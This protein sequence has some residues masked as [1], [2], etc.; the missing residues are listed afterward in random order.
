MVHVFH[1]SDFYAISST[2]SGQLEHTRLLI[3]L[4]SK[5]TIYIHVSGQNQLPHSGE[6][7]VQF[8]NG[9]F[10]LDENVTISKMED[11][12]STKQHLELSSDGTASK[13]LPS[14]MLEQETPSV[15]LPKSS[16]ALLVE[17]ADSDIRLNQEENIEKAS[18]VRN[19]EEERGGWSNKLD[20]LFSCISVSV[21]LGNIWRF[22]YLCKIQTVVKRYETRVSD[23]HFEFFTIRLQKWRRLVYLLSFGFQLVYISGVLYLYSFNIL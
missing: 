8:V 12:E 9:G 23:I 18:D 10:E 5:E 14:G 3:L 15:F 7:D 1:A 17:K 4:I 22:P 13:S 6:M 2:V 19:E 11:D 21:G 20:F 16:T